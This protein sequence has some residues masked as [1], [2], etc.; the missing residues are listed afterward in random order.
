[1]AKKKKEGD[2]KKTEGL[3]PSVSYLPNQEAKLRPRRYR[4]PSGDWIGI[5]G[6]IILPA[7]PPQFPKDRKIR[8]ATPE[9]YEKLFPSH[10]HLINYVELKKSDT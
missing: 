8:E 5:G 4:L 1:M 10:K 2:K 7:K 6:E 3:A 9:E